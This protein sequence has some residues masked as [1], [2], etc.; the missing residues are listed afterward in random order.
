AGPTG[1]QGPAGNDGADGAP[2]AKGDKGDTG[3]T[4][5]QGPQGPVGNAG[6]QYFYVFAQD[7]QVYD[8]SKDYNF[9]VG[10]DNEG[11]PENGRAFI[12]SA[13]TNTPGKLAALINLPNGVVIEKVDVVVDDTNFIGVK[14][15]LW[16]IPFGNN[17]PSELNAG[18]SKSSGQ[19]QTFSFDISREVDTSASMFMLIFEGQSQVRTSISNSIYR[20]RIVYKN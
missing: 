11:G 17:P 10:Y 4:G 7:F 9:N 8:D 19:K 18:T 1:P 16:E 3:A 20:A 6:T 13:E 14:V 2:G 12:I 15:S 5:P